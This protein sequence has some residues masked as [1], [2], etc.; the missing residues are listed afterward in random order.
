MFANRIHRMPLASL[1]VA[2]LAAA[3]LSGLTATGTAA[4]SSNA[5][6][7]SSSASVS[8]ASARLVGTV[9]LSAPAA[10]RPQAATSTSSKYRIVD[11]AAASYH[12]AGKTGSLNVTSS[13]PVNTAPVKGVNG[14]VGLTG[15]EQAVANGGLDLEPPDQGLCAGQGYIVDFINNAFA[16]YNPAGDVEEG[17]LPSYALF[18]QP[19]NSFFSDPRCYYDNPTQRWFFS[20]FVI[21]FNSSGVLVA[22]STQYVA[23]SNTADVFG[24][25]SVLSIDTTDSS[26]PGCPCFGDFDQ[27][28]ADDNGIYISTNEFGDTSGAYNGVIIYAV[29][30]ELLETEAQTGIAATV[31]EYRLPKDQ[32]GSPYHVAPAETPPGAQFATNTEYFVESNSNL[33]S[34]HHLIVYAMTDTSLLAAPAAPPLSHTKIASESYA[35]PPDATQRKGPIPLGKTVQDPEG[36]LE[37]DFNAIQEVTYVNGELYAEADTATAGGHDGVAWF[38]IAPTASGST[39]TAT[40]TAEG[41][42]T[43][44]GENLLYPDIAVNSHGIGDIVFTISGPDY[45]PSAAYIAF[46]ATGPSGAINIAQAGAGPEDSFTCY[47]A[48][49]GPNYGGCRWGDYSMGV[50]MSGK[51]Y[52]ATEFIPNTARDYL[53]NWG[54]YVWGVPANS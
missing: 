10:N 37:A 49:V 16:V 26:T 40:M 51:V 9:A 23:V 42:V 45:Y 30:K 11:S 47:A 54:T 35:F 39:V 34:D 53:T 14:F 12:P 52:L 24:S 31:F 5:T 43:T 2:A 46:G 15:P 18:D 20:E 36:Q 7:V 4:A 25:Y 13:Y 28:G 19:A 33:N 6:P 22:P 29:S 50:A 32:F 21:T 48:F 41:Y 1:S 17:P 44:P 38:A 8:R 3:S 27:F